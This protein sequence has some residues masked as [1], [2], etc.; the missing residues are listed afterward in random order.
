MSNNDYLGPKRL[1]FSAFLLVVGIIVGVTLVSEFHS[2]PSGRAIDETLKE[3]LKRKPP[4]I[5][6]TEQ[7]F[8]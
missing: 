1:I 5:A 6:E 4:A 3:T 2:V 8:V 7:A